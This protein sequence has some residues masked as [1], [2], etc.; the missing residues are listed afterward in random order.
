MPRVKAANLI[1]IS[2]NGYKMQNCMYGG[3]NI[4]N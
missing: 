2:V 1:E 3:V 4:W